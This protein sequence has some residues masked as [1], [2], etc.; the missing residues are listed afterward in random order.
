M[1]ETPSFPDGSVGWT[2]EWTAIGP[3]NPVHLPHN[4]PFEGY[5]THRKSLK[6]L[7]GRFGVPLYESAALTAELQARSV[8]TATSLV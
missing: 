3:Q 6:G 1:E 4:G 7:H 5:S 8:G 2:A